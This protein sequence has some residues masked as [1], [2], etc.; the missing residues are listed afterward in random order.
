MITEIELFRTK[1]KKL[2]EKDQI[3]IPYAVNGIS[4]SNFDYF[5][6]DKNKQEYYLR[7]SNGIMENYVYSSLVKKWFVDD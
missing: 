1:N 6:M 7:Y 2:P 4:I 3:K 5:H